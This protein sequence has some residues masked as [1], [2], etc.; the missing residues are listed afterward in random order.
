MIKLYNLTIQTYILVSITCG[1]TSSENC[2]YFESSGTENAG[3]TFIAYW[4]ICEFWHIPMLLYWDYLP[5]YFQAPVPS[6]YVHAH[7]VYFFESQYSK[8]WY[9]NEILRSPKPIRLR[10]I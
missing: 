4:Y 10:L 5:L 1:S 8:E 9:H 6:R 2:T 3:T 7:P